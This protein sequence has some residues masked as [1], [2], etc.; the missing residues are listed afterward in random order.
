[1]R[2]NTVSGYVQAQ[3]YYRQWAAGVSYNFAGKRS[4]G[5]VVSKSDSYST[6]WASWRPNNHWTL[7]ARWTYMFSPRG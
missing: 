5:N 7:S 6:L 4:L 2:L 3:W 1:M